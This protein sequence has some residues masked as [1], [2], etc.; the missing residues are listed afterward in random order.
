L[1]GSP[2][3]RRWLPLQGVGA[4]GVRQSRT[5]QTRRH[6]RWP[7]HDDVAAARRLDAAACSDRPCAACCTRGDSHGCAPPTPGSTCHEGLHRACSSARPGPGS[8]GSPS[9]RRRTIRAS[10][11][12][13]GAAGRRRADE[14]RLRSAP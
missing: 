3:P 13:A 11:L 9:R 2:P 1:P 14:D 7:G 5:T 12:S 10:R 8:C 4:R 6:G